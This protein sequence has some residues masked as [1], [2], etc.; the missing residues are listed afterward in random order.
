MFL[1]KFIVW[2]LSL[3]C[4]LL[5]FTRFIPILRN[6]IGCQLASK[7]AKLDEKWKTG[8]WKVPQ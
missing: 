4:A 5:H 7:S 1:K 2:S 3:L 6:H 8:I